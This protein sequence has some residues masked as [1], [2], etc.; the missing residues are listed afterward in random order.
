MTARSVF[1]AAF[2]LLSLAVLA[3]TPIAAGF[4]LRDFACDLG[5]SPDWTA[6]ILNFRHIVS[7]GIL[8]TIA[9][10]AFADRP[11]WVPI[12]AT[13]AVTAGAELTEAVFAFG[14]CRLRDM[15]PNVLAVG[16]GLVPAWGIRRFS[17][18]RGTL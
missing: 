17:R 14:H 15:I 7:Y 11:L 3:A 5:P 10:L 16:V 4:A 18:I 6:T 12:V 9:F 1:L 13:L 8:A 2:I